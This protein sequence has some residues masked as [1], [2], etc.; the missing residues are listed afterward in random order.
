MIQKKQVVAVTLNRLHTSGVYL[1]G[2]EAG[3][4]S[5]SFTHQLPAALLELL[6]QTEVDLRSVLLVLREKKTGSVKRRSW[7]AGEA[8]R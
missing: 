2:C 7:R 6:L 8:A 3:R 5:F 1:R 4:S